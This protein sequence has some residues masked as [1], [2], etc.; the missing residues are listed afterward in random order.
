MRRR[1]RSEKRAQAPPGLRLGPQRL[2]IGAEPGAAPSAEKNEGRGEAGRAREAQGPGGGG[3]KEGAPRG[4]AAGEGAA[5]GGRGAVTSWRWL[6]TKL[7]EGLEAP[8]PKKK[9][10]PTLQVVQGSSV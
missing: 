4:A 7:A 9:S 10:A 5:E 3:R 8:P 6:R 2:A 1:E